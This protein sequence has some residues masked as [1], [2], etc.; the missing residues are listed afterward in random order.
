MS[1]DSTAP[2]Q[3][4]GTTSLHASAKARAYD[5]IH[6][7]L[8]VLRTV[9]IFAALAAYYLSGASSHLAQGLTDRFGPLAWEACLAYVALSIFGY[10][11][12]FFPMDQYEGYTLE[13]RFGLSHQTYG[14]WCWDHFKTL[15]LEILFGAVFFSMFYVM[16]WFFPGSWWLWTTLVYGL[17]SVLV[18][19]ILPFWLLPLFYSLEPMEDDETLTSIT[20]FMQ[21]EG[22][23]V[24]GVYRWGLEDKTAAANAAVIGLG[25]TRRIILGDTLLD[26]YSQDEILA[27]LAHEV[28]HCKHHDMVRMLLFSTG[29]ACLGFLGL[30]LFAIQL[31]ASL[32]LSILSDL[33]TYPVLAGCLYL[34]MILVLPIVNLVSRSRE[35]A[36]DAFAVRSLKTA[37]PLTSALTKLATQNLTNPD[38]A[39][40][41]EFLL[42]SHPSIR[43]RVRHAQQVDHQE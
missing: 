18:A 39:P 12:L 38:P 10:W 41:V 4:E 40:W 30:H 28:G 27:V 26:E 8:F 34:Y 15:A 5:R 32:S 35:F 29:L 37:S 22:I 16:A 6:L 7:R 9:C 11:A 21:E 2:P 19:I 20:R 42:H 31:Q 23:G 13:H 33:G 25:N 3:S 1:G 36:A 17:F 14:A 43:R 24:V